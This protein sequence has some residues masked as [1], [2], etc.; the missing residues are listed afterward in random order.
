MR[1]TLVAAIVF[2]CMTSQSGRAEGRLQ[3]ARDGLIQSDVSSIIGT[4]PQTGQRIAPNVR[5]RL[6][7]GLVASRTT[8]DG[9]PNSGIVRRRF[10]GTMVDFYPLGGEGFHLSAG[11]RLDNRRKV[12][13]LATS[14]T[15][16]YA[17]RGFGTRKCSLGKVAS[18]MTVG[19]GS[20]P[21]PGVS[22]GLEAGAL[23]EHGDPSTRELNRFAHRSTRND[24][25]FNS[26]QRLNPVVQASVGYKF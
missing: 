21:E 10:V 23:M 5:L 19:Y 26:S 14:N 12:K 20:S 4:G 15:L 7:P 16:L 3:P 9:D 1:L 22:F 24:I 25:R 8:R 18:A 17:P 13:D 11:G 2:A 6:D